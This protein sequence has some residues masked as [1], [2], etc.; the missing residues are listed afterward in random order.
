M[1]KDEEYAKARVKDIKKA[2]EDGCDDVK[3]VLEYMYPDL[4]NKE[5]CCDWMG[6]EIHKGFIIDG[7]YDFAFENNQEFRTTSTN[8]IFY[9]PRCGKKSQ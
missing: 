7:V 2:H 8:C 4:L 1:K 3:G 9:C 6:R 5:Y